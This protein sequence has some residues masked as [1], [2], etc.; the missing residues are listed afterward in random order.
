M[1][2]GLFEKVQGEGEDVVLLH[3]LFGQGSNLQSIARALESDFRV[4]SVDLPD[5]GRSPWSA[6]PSINA[7]ADAL[8]AWMTAQGIQNAHVLGHSLGGKVA[9]SLALQRPERV[10]RL[11]VA[12][13]AP[14]SYAPSHDAVFQGLQAVA[15]AECAT[16]KQACR[17]LEDFIEEPNVRQFLLLSLVR[18]EGA[19][20][21]TWRLNHEALAEAYPSLLLGLTSTTPCERP[22]LFLRGALSGY[23]GNDDVPVIERLFP[24]FRLSTLAGAGHWLHVEAPK[25]FNE[26]VLAFLKGA[27]AP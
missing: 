7:Y 2:K 19:K 11:V 8:D 26:E 4:H 10:N 12:D 3:G 13:I 24:H 23:V 27:N 9:M 20:T 6:G 25:V 5:H 18:E 16:R 15:H 1:G 17:V 22:A 14:V 21:F